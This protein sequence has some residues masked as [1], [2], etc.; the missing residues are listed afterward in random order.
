MDIGNTSV[1]ERSVVRNLRFVRE[2]SPLLS[3]AQ[4]RWEPARPAESNEAPQEAWPQ[5]VL[6]SVSQPAREPESGNGGEAGGGGS[7]IGGGDPGVRVDL[8][9]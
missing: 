4:V 5:S 6:V 2:V 3:P 9:V 8:I 7:A 1:G